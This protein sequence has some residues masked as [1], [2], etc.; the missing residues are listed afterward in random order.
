MK[1]TN[2]S[3]IVNIANQDKRYLLVKLVVTN[4]A[5]LKPRHSRSATRFATAQINKY[6]LS[7]NTAD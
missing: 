4:R 1:Y 2:P 7:A 5:L 6:N 3:N